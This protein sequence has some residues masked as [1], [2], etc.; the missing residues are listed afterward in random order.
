MQLLMQCK[1]PMLTFLLLIRKVQ[2]VKQFTGLFL[3]AR[4]LFSCLKGYKVDL[5]P[6]ELYAMACLKRGHRT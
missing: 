3:H 4:I 5:V 6:A 1:I 2:G